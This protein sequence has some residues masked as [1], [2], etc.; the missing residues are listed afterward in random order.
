M[1]NFIIGNLIALILIIFY[2]F[3][4]EG[5]IYGD[6]IGIISSLLISI[7]LQRKYIK[8][9]FSISKIKR[10]LTFSLPLVPTHIVGFFHGNIDKILITY[11][12]NLNE[13]GIYE[14]ANRTSRLKPFVC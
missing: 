4:Y 1:I 12:R 6:L 10:S 13:F 11:F 7:Y 5:K 2:S 14:L 3:N 8:P 9:L